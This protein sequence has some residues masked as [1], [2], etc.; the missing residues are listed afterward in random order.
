MSGCG[1]TQAQAVTFTDTNPAD[2][3]PLLYTAAFTVSD[4]TT[5][6][7]TAPTTT[8]FPPGTD[9]TYDIQVWVSGVPT[10]TS[11]ADEFMG[12]GPG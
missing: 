1:F 3:T 2:G 4:D 10:A 5:L 11:V 8:G 9:Y 12:Q 7:V 6:N